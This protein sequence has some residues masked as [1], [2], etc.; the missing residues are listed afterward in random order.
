[1]AQYDNRY[2][3]AGSVARTGVAIDEGLRAHARRLQLHGGRRGSHGLVAY[4]VFS[5]AVTMDP[6]LAAKRHRRGDCGAACI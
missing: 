1:M 4:L 3:S 5:M 6:A 2:A